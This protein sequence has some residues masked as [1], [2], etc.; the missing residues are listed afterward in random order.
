M[1]KILYPLIFILFASLILSVPAFSDSQAVPARAA[2]TMMTQYFKW[3]EMGAAALP[4]IKSAIAGDNW[5]MKTHALLAAGKIGDKSMVPQILDRLRHDTNRAVKNCAVKALGDLKAKQALP[6]LLEV[7]NPETPGVANEPVPDKK[8][9]IG[10]LGKIGDKQAVIPLCRLLFSSRNEEVKN[11]IAKAII[12]IGDSRA[13]LFILSAHRKD[14]GLSGFPLMQAA[15]IIGRLPVKNGEDFLLTLVSD[16]PAPVRNAAADALSRAGT[17]KSIPT[18]VSSFATPDPFFR[19]KIGAALVAISAESSVSPMCDFLKNPDKPIAMDAADVL[20]RMNTDT[21]AEAVFSRLKEDPVYNAAAAYVLGAKAYDPAIPVLRTRLQMS[22]Q[23]G[24]DEMAEAL[25]RMKDRESIPLLISI[26]K[27]EVP[28]GPAGAVR[29]LGEMKANQA[30]PVLFS[31]LEGRNPRLMDS[32]IFALGEIGD[33]A[34]ARPLIDLYY[35]SGL[36][37]QFQVG[38]ALAQIGG[39]NVAQFIKDNMESGNTKR[40][41]MAGFMLLKSKDKTLIPYALSLLDDQDKSIRTCALGA[42]K[43]MTGLSYDTPGKWK[44]WGAEKHPARK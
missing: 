41:R 17:Y 31:L 44:A 29:A 22:G 19:K 7:L 40:R 20:S 35:E 8:L 14:P 34:A 1:K 3:V 2:D 43:N 26:A 23:P 32:V 12:A 6:V 36:K 21:I 38:L 15:A 27:Q 25:G 4:E 16:N 24:R 30:M 39:R 9:I 28:D 13:S 5:R 18:L 42:L 10:A 11:T 33:P 37:Y